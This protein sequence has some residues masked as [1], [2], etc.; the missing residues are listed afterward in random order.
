MASEYKSKS[1]KVRRSMRVTLPVSVAYDLEK[2][3]RALANV[4]AMVGGAGCA[5]DV[6]R[7][8]LHARE[9]VVDPA[10]LEAREA[11]GER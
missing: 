4:A 10:S 1:A 9:F 11:T 2:F 6:G 8:F 3:Q 7:T 5:G